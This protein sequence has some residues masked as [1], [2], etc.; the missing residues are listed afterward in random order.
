MVRKFRTPFEAEQAF[1]DAMERSDI[2]SMQAVWSTDEAVVCI[3]PGA[4]RLEGRDRVVQ[5]FSELFQGA[6]NVGYSITDVQCSTFGNVAVHQVREEIEVDGQ[7]VSIMVATN[8][9]K[10]ENGSWNMMLHHAS[11][12]PEPEFDELDYMMEYEE[13]VVLH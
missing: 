12:E 13:P 9:Y 7:L 3:H 10:F 8:I 6:P 4:V 11:H 2:R 5:S 1:Y